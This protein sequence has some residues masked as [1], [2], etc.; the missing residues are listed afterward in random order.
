MSLDWR[1]PVVLTHRWLGMSLGLLVAMWFITGMVMMYA[2]MPR[3]PAIERL[4]R[5]EPLEF[6]RAH[7]SLPEAVGQRHLG[8]VHALRIVMLLGRPVYHVL[9][10]RGWASISS[11][12][13]QLLAALNRDEALELARR[14]DPIDAATMRYDTR[15]V[16]ADQWTLENRTLLPLHRIA[17]GDPLD[18]YL[19]VSERSGDMEL[20]TTGRE[21]RLAYAGAVLHWLYFAPL[22]R[23]GTAWAQT[24]I[25]VSLAACLMCGAGLLWGVYLGLP[26]PHRGLMRWHHRCGL[27]FGA[28]TLTWTFSGLLSL[29]PWDWHPSTQPTREQRDAFSGGP[30]R[31]DE[32]LFDRVRHAAVERISHGLRTSAREIEIVPFRGDARVIVDGQTGNLIDRSALIAAARDAMPGTAIADI[33]WLDEYDAYYY[34]RQRELP[35]PILRVRY[36]DNAHTWLYIDAARGAIVRKEERLTRLNRWLYHGLHSLDFPFLYGRRP[37][38]DL[39]VILLSVGGLSSAI[40]AARPAWRRLRRRM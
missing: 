10:D 12:N 4:A 22:R 31:L 9:T 8:P 36:S 7:V 30:V 27:V 15:L 16:D 19:Y 18:T 21:R 26:S 3:L 23:H 1:R 33:A 20:R 24:I 5:L 28:A 17:V 40:T 2:R 32:R 13:G 11:E 39:I 14:F 35:L 38:W 37:L 6:S 25:W 34:D 29:D